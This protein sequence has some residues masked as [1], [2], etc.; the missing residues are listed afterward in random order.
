MEVPKLANCLHLKES[1]LLKPQQVVLLHSLILIIPPTLGSLL[2]VE[3]AELGPK[4]A[5]ARQELQNP[6]PQALVPHVGA[7]RLQQAWGKALL[8]RRGGSTE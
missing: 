5:V 7:Q 2:Q 1:Q 3:P 4:V 6:D 8:H